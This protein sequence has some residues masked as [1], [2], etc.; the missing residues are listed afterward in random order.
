VGIPALVTVDPAAIAAHGLP[1]AHVI[2]SDPLT[3]GEFSELLARCEQ[4]RL[5]GFMARA[6]HDGT[7]LLDDEQHER[8]ELL[9]RGWLEHALR[10]ERLVVDATLVLDRHRIPSRVLKGVA[11]SHTAYD[12]PDERVFGDADLLVP[13]DD[14]S[15]SS[16]VLAD[17]LDGRRVQPELRRGFDDRFGK[18]AM[19]DVGGLE[20]DLHRTFVEGAFGLT[21][22]LDDLFT[23][24]YRFP[25]GMHE[26]E[27]LPMPQRFLHA[28]YAAAFGDWP[29]RLAS[30]RDLAQLV[31][32][33][34]PVLTDVLLMAREWRCEP[35]VAR[36]VTLAWRELRLQTRF[37]VVEWAE[38]HQPTRHEARM[39]A[40]HEGPARAF[41]SQAA[42]VL[43]LPSWDDRLAYV[44]AVAFPD[45][46]YLGARGLT[47]R[48]HVKRAW[49]RLVGRR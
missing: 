14:L 2:P 20:L 8:F 43:V 24:P 27:A 33:E 40:W 47:S 30:L 29:P 21:V 15:R 46:D 16:R 49:T 1:S 18:E 3:D 23:P 35:I 36:A 26:L 9:F 44:R 13:A 48:S 41:T 6:V 38:R 19:L 32:R 42:A 45:R 4:D 11:L 7:L 10:I 25:L 12:T 31:H 17:A 37:P 39:L 34:R 5:L 22:R 28:S